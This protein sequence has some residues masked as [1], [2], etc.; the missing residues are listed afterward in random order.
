[1]PAC[2]KPSDTAQALIRSASAS[3]SGGCSGVM[4]L[5]YG[6]IGHASIISRMSNI[7]NHAYTPA[8]VREMD[9]TAIERLGIPGYTLMTRAGQA[10]F[11]DARGQFP[12]ARRW[13]VLCGAGNNAGDGY[14]VARL[15]RVA[16]LDVT[17][18]AI[19]D[20][21]K[22][23]GDAATARDDYLSNGATIAEFDPAQIGT[24]DLVLDAMLGTGL[25]R[26]LGGAYLDAVNAL[27]TTRVPV[28]AV[29]IPTGLNGETGAIMGAAVRADLTATFV[30]SKQGLYLGSGPEHAGE[31]RFHD[32]GI[33][34]AELAAIEPT[35]R[36]HA[37]ADSFALLGRRGRADHKGK[38]GHVLIV[39]GNR[40]MGGAPRLA[41]EAALRVG[42]GLVS[43]AA[44]PDVAASITAGRPELMCHG[45]RGPDDLDELL[46]RATVVALGP[47]LGRDD[48]SWR[49]FQRII[50]CRQPKIV[51]A[52]A[53]NILAEESVRRDDWIL[54]PHP[55]EAARLLGTDSGAV[56]TDR[57]AAVAHIAA[58]Y[59]GVA[60]LKGHGTLI[61]APGEQPVLVRRGN[62]GMATAG[63]GDVL[64]GVA[65]GLLAQFPDEALRTA[66][67]AVDVHASAGDLAA[68]SGE[69]GL[70][71]S[72]LFAHLRALVNPAR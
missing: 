53:L 59:G 36:L 28:I 49:I 40:G 6:D 69:R 2:W 43:V 62:P 45:V 25:D 19:S 55:G 24:A 33:P 23:T 18:A 54:T 26:P 57:L 9:R 39:G 8:A 1:M 67:V 58:R 51:D 64:T 37:D 4:L 20:P 3:S 65:A 41:G 71:A 60:V 22:L 12:A 5:A 32:L 42:A 34:A 61:Q 7:E 68:A 29:D 35:L 48:W 21:A 70:I 66:A 10:T 30:G 13:L 63:M 27:A 11:D 47:G 14:V 72:D 17:V 50:G 31:V 38:F 52:D 15:A 56:Q 46:D 16:G 44:H